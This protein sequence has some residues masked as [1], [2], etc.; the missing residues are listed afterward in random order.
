MKKI[1]KTAGIRKYRNIKKAKQKKD[2]VL[3][4]HSAPR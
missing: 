1:M 2:K 3:K 4:S